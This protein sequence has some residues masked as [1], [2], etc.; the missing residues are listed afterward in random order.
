MPPASMVVSFA[1]DMRAYGAAYS[2]K[3]NS[4]ADLT[5]LSEHLLK[6]LGL[7]GSEESKTIEA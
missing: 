6:L 3:G 4:H 7:A 2:V 5:T 1:L